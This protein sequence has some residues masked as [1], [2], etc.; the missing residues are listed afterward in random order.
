MARGIALAQV[1]AVASSP[2]L[3]RIFGQD[4]FGKL[5]IFNSFTDIAAAVGALCYEMAIV[6]A[7]TTHEAALLAVGCLA[8]SCLTGLLAS[9]AL[10]GLI[11][12]EVLGL[13]SL[14]L[15]SVPIA[16]VTIVLG[17][18]ASQLRYWSIRESRYDLISHATVLRVGTRAAGQL[19]LGLLKAGWVGLLVGNLLGVISGIWL[20]ARQGYAGIKSAL[21]PFRRSD[22]VRVLKTERKFPLYSCPSTLLNTLVLN[23]ALP[24]IAALHGLAVAGSYTLVQCAVSLPVGFIS[25][26]VADAFHGQVTVYARENRP[27]LRGFLLKT[28]AQLLLLG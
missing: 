10:S 4:D 11:T 12:F 1:L 20:M 2:I 3:T 27:A 8:L 22:V 23:L 9:A 19:G 6:T 26:S 7:A 24:I 16:F 14:P 21:Q 5:G 13:G 25:G 15:W 17:S 18:L 28:A